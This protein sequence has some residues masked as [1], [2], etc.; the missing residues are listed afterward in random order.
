MTLC[1]KD[2]S[3]MNFKKI[4]VLRLLPGVVDETLKVCRP[5]CKAS[6]RN[7][8]TSMHTLDYSKIF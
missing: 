4:I 1:R 3:G 2:S 5:R 8:I 7:N 6:R